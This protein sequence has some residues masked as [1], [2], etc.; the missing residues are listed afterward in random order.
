MSHKKEK[1]KSENMRTTDA[2]VVSM[3]LHPQDVKK[4][5]H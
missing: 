1:K 5:K 4:V 2:N 3:G